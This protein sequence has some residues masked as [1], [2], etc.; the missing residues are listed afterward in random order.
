M[1]KL[2]YRSIGIAAILDSRSEAGWLAGALPRDAQHA[3]EVVKNR[4]GLARPDGGLR[5]LA[6]GHF[7]AA[8]SHL[9]NCRHPRI[10]RSAIAWE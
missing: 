5:R 6:A 7:G 9:A 8:R 1:Q 10:W 4:A 2:R 3:A